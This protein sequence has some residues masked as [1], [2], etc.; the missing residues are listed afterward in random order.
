[1]PADTLGEDVSRVEFEIAYDGAE[2]LHEM[3]VTRLGPALIG[4]GDLI[5]EA[6]FQ[7]NGDSAKVNLVVTSDFEH[8]CFN[9]NFELVQTILDKVI[10]FVQR[11]DVKTAHDILD[12]IGFGAVVTLHPLLQYLK[13][14][15][16]RKI[17]E[18]VDQSEKGTI[19]LK[20][21]GDDNRVEVHQHVYQMGENTVIRNGI[22]NALGPIEG[23]EYERVEIRRDGKPVAVITREEVPDIKASCQAEKDDSLP[24]S[25]EEIATLYA[26]GPVFDEDA[27]HWRFLYNGKHI[28]VDIS[29]TKI[30]ADAMERG[31]VYTDDMYRVRLKITEFPHVKR[32]RPQYKALEIV[33]FR[34]G[35]RQGEMF[36]DE[37]ED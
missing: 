16:G 24:N 13:L 22:E 37:R 8:K 19:N 28:N 18:K 2:D 5:R 14:R 10:G 36:K 17:E 12:W 25:R 6:N 3:D 23:G 31:A 33:G 1:M 29:E 9:I 21:E 26:Y 11:E 27:E 20:F 34:P 7:I 30:A 4:L 15:K 35:N 32:K